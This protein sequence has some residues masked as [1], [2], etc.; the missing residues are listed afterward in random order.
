MFMPLLYVIVT[1]FKPYDE[2]FLFP[3]RFYVQNPTMD[4]W[5]NLIGAFD[6]SAVPFLRY[7]YNSL[8]TTLI[9]VVSTIMVCSLGAYGFSKKRVPFGGLIFGI[10][11][12]ALAVPAHVTQIPNY[13]VVNGLGFTNTMWALIIPKIGVAYNL[14]LMKQFCDPIPDVLLEAARIDGAGEGLIFFKLILPSLRPAWVTL[15]VFS[16]VANWND[17]F[18]ALV[19][20]TDEAKKTLP[21]ILTT[22]SNGGDIARAGASAAGTFLM[23]MPTILIY[24]SMQK[25]VIETMTYSGIKG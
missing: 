19:Y 6:S 24:L 16:F 9:T 18:S 23:V 12:A 10:I 17:Y 5:K 3:P 21:L 13:M 1:A 15:V 4:N 8:I 20:I 11:V 7:V 2:L 22:L 14:F 25:S